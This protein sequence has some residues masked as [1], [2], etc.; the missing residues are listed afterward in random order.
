MRIT[1]VSR[2]TGLSPDQIR[3]MEQKGYIQPGM[4]VIKSRKVRDY[5]SDDISLL[6]S[7]S[8]YLSQGYRYEV[9]YVKA[10]EDRTNPRLVGLVDTNPFRLSRSY[11]LQS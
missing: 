11:A 8:N 2:L 9:A 1:L 7:I 3:Y 5:S 10:L 6:K 4:V